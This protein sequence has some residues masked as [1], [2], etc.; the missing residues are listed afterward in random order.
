[1]IIHKSLKKLEKIFI[2]QMVKMANLL[3]YILVEA[4]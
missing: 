3:T 4:N 1:M 2:A